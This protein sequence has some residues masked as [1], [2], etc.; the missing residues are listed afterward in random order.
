MKFFYK[1]ILIVVIFY[2]SSLMSEM[3]CEVLDYKECKVSDK[4]KLDC[5][6]EMYSNLTKNDLR[7]DDPPLKFINVF[8]YKHYPEWPDIPKEKFDG[9]LYF[10]SFEKYS[11]IYYERKFGFKLN[12]NNRRLDIYNMRY[13]HIAKI[14]KFLSITPNKTFILTEP[15]YMNSNLIS[16]ISSGNC[17]D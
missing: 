15:I 14:K 17:H 8:S 5:S 12:N 11:K 2:S 4:G 10:E 13:P 9:Y 16:R 7:V 6:N 1:I 3:I